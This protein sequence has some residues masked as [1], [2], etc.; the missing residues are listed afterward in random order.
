MSL[1]VLQILSAHP[2]AAADTDLRIR[3]LSLLAAANIHLQHDEDA[4]R[5]LA[6]ADQLCA[7][8]DSAVCTHDLS[9]HWT[10]ATEHGQY[11]EAFRLASQEVSF[12]HRFAQP[13]DE[14]TALTNLAFTCLH[15]ERFDEAIDRLNASDRIAVPI[16]AQDLLVTNI[17]NL[18]WAYFSLGDS[19]RALTL[20][21]D[22]E[23]RAT[24]LGD[25]DET[26]IWLTASGYVFQDAHDWPRARDAYLTA[27]QFARNID[28]NENIV[29]SLEDLAHISIQLNRL[30]EAD[31]YLRQLDP[32]LAANA[33]RLDALDVTLARGRIA[34]GR[35]QDQQAEQLFRQV[36][37]DPASQITMRLGAEHQLAR[38]YEAEHRPDDAQKMYATALATFE[39]ARA[40]IRNE[41][42]KLPYFANATPIYDDSIRLLIAQ[43]RSEQAL[44]AADQ[45]RARTLT[46]GLGLIA[47]DRPPH[48]LPYSPEAIAARAG[49]TLLFYWLGE[50]QSWLWAVTPHKTTVFPLPPAAEIARRVERYRQVLLGPE[51]PL[52]P[53]DQDGLAL[54]RILVA[55]AGDLLPPGGK[56]AVLCDGAL[57]RLN[58]E[59]LIVPGPVPHYWIEDA[60]IV[61]APSLLMLASSKP[62]QPG[63]RRLLMI[64]NAVSPSEDYPE[65]S[66]AGAEMQAIRRHFQ[67]R[68]ETVFE[69]RQANPRAYLDAGPERYAYIDFVAHG[70][71]SRTDPLDSAIILS[72]TSPGTDSFRLH[73]RDIM[74][75]PVDARLVTIAACYG[76]G[77]RAYAGEGLV[78][79]SWA[80]LYAGAHN[81]IGALWEVSDA[82]TPLLMDALYQGLQ[83]GLSPSA[84]LRQAKLSLLHGS[85]AFRRPFYW[86]PFQLYTGT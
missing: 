44:A 28:S 3:R 26:V 51:D 5:Y 86:G 61:S 53:A 1:Q 65:L 36:E 55:P 34:A 16:D 72:R 82:S 74:Q 48:P 66:N 57:S 43:G 71:A 42:S 68:A 17:G 30:D 18:G 84:A 80:F 60:D 13:L 76:G 78:G 15:E 54:Y 35:R 25:E 37:A 9:A 33:N 32:L 21:Q 8:M 6:Q 85:A 81:V 83:D 22:A 23:R 75:R 10:L 69:R 12:A 52:A 45:S 58:F 2:R 19:E 31:T 49:A 47:A 11:D 63:N 67:P 14:A 62:E 56:V 40:R 79:L 27:L 70:V 50:Q 46:Q 38:L 73:A 77:T 7:A 41:D 29:N 39:S 64:G 24:A 4:A 20:F 59:T